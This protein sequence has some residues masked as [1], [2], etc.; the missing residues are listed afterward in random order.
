M[1]KV[2]QT[3]IMRSWRAVETG[4][5]GMGAAGAELAEYPAETRNQ[6]EIRRVWEGECGNDAADDG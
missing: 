6:P 4:L 2:R 5:T 1:D 3:H